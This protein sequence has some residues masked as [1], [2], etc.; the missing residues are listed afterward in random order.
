MAKKVQKSSKKISTERLLVNGSMA[1]VMLFVVDCSAAD[2]RTHNAA[3][4]RAAAKAQIDY[5]QIVLRAYDRMVDD[6]VDAARGYRDC[7]AGQIGRLNAE[8]DAATREIEA[9]D[10]YC[11]RLINKLRQKTK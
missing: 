3:V 4:R 8:Y 11:I 1:L 9:R 7:A 5:L 2:I 10:A 6:G